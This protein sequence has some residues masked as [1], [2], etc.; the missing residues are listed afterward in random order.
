MYSG[1]VA[2]S[3]VIAPGRLKNPDN[4]QYFGIHQYKLQ[5]FIFGFSDSIILPAFWTN[6]D[7]P[8]RRGVEV[9]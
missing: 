3:N 4:Y 8:H 1:G 5:I 7:F 6:D 2:I 9:V